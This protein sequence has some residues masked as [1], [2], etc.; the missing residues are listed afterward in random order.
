MEFTGPKPTATSRQSKPVTERG[1]GARPMGHIPAYTSLDGSPPE[2]SRDL[3]EI[4]DISEDGVSIQTASPLE[5]DHNLNLCLDL[6][7]TKTRIRT[8]GRVVWSNNSGRAGIRFPKLTGQSLRQLRE[9]L[10]V[11]VLTAFDHARGGTTP[12]DAGAPD[13]PS[14]GP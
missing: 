7:E 10:F 6:S 12:A 14:S 3:S 9:W 1:P 5:V 8:T 13:A 4:L 2:K 11:N